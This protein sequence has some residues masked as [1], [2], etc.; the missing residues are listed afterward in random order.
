MLKNMPQGN[1]IVRILGEGKF[2]D[3]PLLNVEFPLFSPDARGI[4]RHLDAMHAES[5]FAR[6]LEEHSRSTSQVKQGAGRDETL[7]PLHPIMTE[8]LCGE[9]SLPLEVFVQS[10]ILGG[11]IACELIK[12]QLRCRLSESAHRTSEYGKHGCINMLIPVHGVPCRIQRL[13][14]TDRT[15]VGYA[16]VILRWHFIPD[17]PLRRSVL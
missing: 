17:Y 11:I 1:D 13:T 6:S 15:R 16:C 12:R 8:P 3:V 2:I 10:V 4:L 7:D 9:A 5:L 14:G